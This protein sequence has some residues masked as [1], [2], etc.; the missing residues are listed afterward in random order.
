MRKIRI[1]SMSIAS[2]WREYPG[3]SEMFESMSEVETWVLED[4][5][6]VFER[7]NQWV[8]DLNSDEKVAALNDKADALLIVLYFL[9]T[10]TSMYLYRSLTDINPTLDRAL[11]FTANSWLQKNKNTIIATVFWDRF[12]ELMLDTSLKD[13][14]GTKRLQEIQQ[15]IE[16]VSK[17]RGGVQ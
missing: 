2:Y 7:I 6:E 3:L 9:S 11:Q 10:R 14:L 8:S 12:R 13:F 4:E 17:S 15:C 1:D 5:F 16:H